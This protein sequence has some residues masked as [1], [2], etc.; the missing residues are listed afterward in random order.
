[1]KAQ[2]ITVF[3]TQQAACTLHLPQNILKSN[4]QTN[5]Q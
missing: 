1:M 5:K 4:K 2:L 3:K